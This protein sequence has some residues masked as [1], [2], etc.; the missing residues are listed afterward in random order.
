VPATSPDIGLPGDLVDL[1]AIVINRGGSASFAIASTGTAPLEITAITAFGGFG[2]THNCN[3]PVEPGRS[4]EAIVSFTPPRLGNFSGDLVIEFLPAGSFRM[5]KLRALG[6]EVPRPRIGLSSNA[7]SFGTR[8]VGNAE[9]PS[10]KVFVRSIGSAP[11]AISGVAASQGYSV[12]SGCPAVLQPGRECELDIAF[13][14]QGLGRNVG[15]ASVQ[16][17]D[18]DSP[19]ASIRLDGTGCHAPSVTSSRSGGKPCGP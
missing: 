4:C 12:K 8:I 14:P 5:L 1:G 19:V 3:A 18:P 15:T 11:L 2:V 9:T 10:E 16:S 7:L 6:V 17:D 13:K